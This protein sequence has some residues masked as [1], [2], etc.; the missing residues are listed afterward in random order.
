MSSFIIFEDKKQ[1]RI[2][3]KHQTEHCY[4][5][6]D[7]TNYRQSPNNNFLKSSIPLFFIDERIVRHGEENLMGGN[8]KNGL[9]N[10][11]LINKLNKNIG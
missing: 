9:T 5:L 2:K 6:F 7:C 1:N 4:F 8:F 10:L 3:L 11:E